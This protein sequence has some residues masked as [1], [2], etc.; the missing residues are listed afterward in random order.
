MTDSDTLP[1]RSKSSIQDREL[2]TLALEG[3]QRAYSRLVRKYRARLTY[4][5]RRTIGAHNNYE[6][7]DLVQEAFA[8]AF[9]A[10]DSYSADYAFS[11]WIYKIAT[12]HAIDYRRKKRLQTSSIHQPVKTGEGEMEMDLPDVTYRPDRHIVESQQRDLI[13]RAIDRL[14][15]KYRQV[16]VLRHQKEMAYA[17]IAETLNLPLGTVKAHIFR[18]RSA[19]YK[20][21]RGKE[22][23]LSY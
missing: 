23:S 6:I 10:L 9:G 14:P 13:Q 1:G 8:K 3:D 18:A 15:E 17:D 7:D 5:I 2:V 16:I 21:L 11:T 4:H 19:L 22:D 12:N 20:Y